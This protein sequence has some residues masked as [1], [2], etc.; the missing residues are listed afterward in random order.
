MT[1]GMKGTGR[2]RSEE[3]SRSPR[4]E[5]KDRAG[6]GKPGLGFS[7]GCLI[8]PRREGNRFRFGDSG[9]SETETQ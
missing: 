4:G 3:K 9:H 5:E 8:L 2:D 7:L 1:A 6:Q